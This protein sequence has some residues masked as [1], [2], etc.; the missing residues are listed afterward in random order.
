MERSGEE[1]VPV[2]VP[3]PMQCSFLPAN[4]TAAEVFP[5]RLRLPLSA[6]CRLFQVLNNA[7][8]FRRTGK[9][10][11]EERR[12]ASD[13]LSGIEKL[14]GFFRRRLVDAS[15]LVEQEY[16]HFFVSQRHQRQP[17]NGKDEQDENDES[18]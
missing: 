5:H 4:Q 1:S 17:G 10:N 12:V 14:E 13:D 6:V 11:D 9:G 18:E 15:A 7:G 3:E 8:R 16:D 2:H